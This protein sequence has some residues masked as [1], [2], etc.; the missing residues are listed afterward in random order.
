MT[1]QAVIARPGQV[2]QPIKDKRADR[3]PWELEDRLG[4][5]RLIEW[6]IKNKSGQMANTTE[7]F[8]NYR[9]TQIGIKKLGYA[10][11]VKLLILNA[12][13]AMSGDIQGKNKLQVIQLLEEKPILIPGGAGLYPPV[14]PAPGIFQRVKGLLGMDKGEK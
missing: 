12:K 1:Q 7:E 8:Q 2:D 14:E 5:N 9:A 6:V 4:R 10:S 3:E 11:G 13:A